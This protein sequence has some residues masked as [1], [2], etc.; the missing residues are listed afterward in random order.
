[1]V[2]RLKT[3][4]A[5]DIRPALMKEFNYGNIMQVPQLTKIV[6]NIG[7]GEALQNP[8]A[9]EAATQDLATITGQKPIIT[10]ARKSIATFKLRQ[11]N[12]IGTCV[13]LRGS[14]M[15]DFLDRLCNVALLRQRDQ[16][17][18]RHAA[19]AQP[20]VGRIA[21]DRAL[22]QVRV[23]GAGDALRVGLQLAVD[24]VMAGGF[25]GREGGRVGSGTG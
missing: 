8:K 5:N 4:Y 9:M 15:Y 19:Q 12:P 13:T 24:V 6:V 3:K 17:F 23:Q 14:R 25:D 21:E 20:L 7:L 16:F 2:A 10:R 11:G 22:G 1:M 18:L